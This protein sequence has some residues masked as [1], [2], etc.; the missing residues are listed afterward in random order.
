[1]REWLECECPD[2]LLAF[3]CGPGGPPDA[4]KLRLFACA[5]CRRIRGHVAPDWWGL[6]ELCERRAGTVALEWALRA[7]RE[8]LRRNWGWRDKHSLEAM[9]EQAVELA[10]SADLVRA[11]PD[12]LCLA[13]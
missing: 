5:C 6:I 2:R 3:L 4:R 9:A 8:K 10:A 1:E 13:R 7:A 11:T 12:V